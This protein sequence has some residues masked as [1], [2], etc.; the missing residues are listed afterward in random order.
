MSFFVSFLS[1]DFF[2]PFILAF[3]FALGVVSFP[4][5]SEARLGVFAPVGT[6][7]IGDEVG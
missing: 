6:V 7:L 3:D 5:P 1:F 2:L 4:M